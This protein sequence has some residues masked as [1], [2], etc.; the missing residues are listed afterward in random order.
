MMPLSK[1]DLEQ[2]LSA[3]K[4]LVDGLILRGYINTIASLPGEGKTA[5]L[6][7]LAWQVSR[8]KGEFLEC[9]VAHGITLYVDFDAPGE[10]RTVR[11]WLD[12]HKKVFPDGDL[13]KIVVLEPDLD[14]YGLAAE[15]LE[16][17]NTIAKETQAKLI[18]ID[19]FSSA[20]PTTDPIKLTQ[21]QGPLWHLRCLAVETGAAV[22]I[23]DHLPKPISGE[24]AGARGIIGSVAKSAQARAVH[25]LSRVPPKDVQGKNVLRWDTTKMSY[26]ARPKPFGIELSFADNAVSINVVALP[27]GQ[28]ETRTEQAV[29]AMQNHLESYRGSVITHQ[30]L[31]DIAMHE[32]NLRRRASID[33]VQLLKEKYGDELVTTFLPG[34]GKPQGYLLRLENSTPSL[35]SASLHQIGDASF[36]TVDHSVQTYLD[37]SAPETQKTAP[38]S[39]NAAP[40]PSYKQGETSGDVSE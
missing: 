10:G 23:A 21:V 30:E 5:L 4:W 17:L 25:I 28:G 6:T 11:Y 14:T 13:S 12:K 19:S 31:L 26:S 15:E 16:Q 8:L 24:K 34:R 9:C 18:L 38:N 3:L 39:Q 2:D 29:R 32:G 1:V 7:G 36:E 27:K 35:Y 33:A 37:H 40:N 20:F 22:V